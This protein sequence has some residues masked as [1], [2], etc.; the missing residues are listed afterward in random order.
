M[1]VYRYFQQLLSHLFIKMIFQW[2]EKD[3]CNH[4]TSMT[5]VPNTNSW[6][7]LCILFDGD[8][9]GVLWGQKINIT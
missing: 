2:S 5:S 7:E 4:V 9:F 3:T 6:Y 1:T 8:I